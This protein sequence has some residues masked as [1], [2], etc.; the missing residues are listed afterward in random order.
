MEVLKVVGWALVIVAVGVILGSGLV[1][2]I[3]KL[4]ELGDKEMDKA[5][6][7]IC[8]YNPELGKSVLIRQGSKTVAN[9]IE[10]DICNN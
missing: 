7:M 4:T 9:I 5:G 10:G 2:G 6:K 8:Q 3:N 1:L